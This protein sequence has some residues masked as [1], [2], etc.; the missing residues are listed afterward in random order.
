MVRAISVQERIFE[1]PFKEGMQTAM[2]S[3]CSSLPENIFSS[4][5][6]TTKFRRSK[7]EKQDA[8]PTQGWSISSRFVTLETRCYRC[9]SATVFPL[10]NQLLYSIRTLRSIRACTHVRNDNTFGTPLENRFRRVKYEFSFSF[11]LF[12]SYFG[13]EEIW[14]VTNSWYFINR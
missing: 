14:V 2:I 5:E 4:R 12:L 6:V 8:T 13:E 11:F 9:H 3:V 7:R 1:F 10:Y